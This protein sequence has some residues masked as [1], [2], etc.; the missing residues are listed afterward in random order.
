MILLM[1]FPFFFTGVTNGLKVKGVKVPSHPVTGKD[2]EME[3][4]Y[5]LEGSDL[6]SVKW[7]RGD[8]EFFRYVP[9]DRPPMLVFELPGV[10]VN[11]S[12][13]REFCLNRI[14]V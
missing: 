5:D 12:I 11:V 7:Y 2:V 1:I 3:C 10:L 6:Y 13:I 14:L 9:G 4:D 8:H